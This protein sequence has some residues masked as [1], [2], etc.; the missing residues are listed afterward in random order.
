MECLLAPQLKICLILF[1]SLVLFAAAEPQIIWQD[2]D[3]QEYRSSAI[4]AVST[5]Q[6][7][8]VSRKLS[9]YDSLPVA[10]LSFYVVNSVTPSRIFSAAVSVTSTSS[11][12]ISATSAQLSALVSRQYSSQIT[13]VTA[14]SHSVSTS[15]Q[16]LLSLTTAS[17]GSIFGSREVFSISAVR[18]LSETSAPSLPIYSQELH[19]RLSGRHSAE[20]TSAPLFVSVLMNSMTCA[21][22]RAPSSLMLSPSVAL[23]QIFSVGNLV[24]SPLSLSFSVLAPSAPVSH[25]QVSLSTAKFS[26]FGS[27]LPDSQHGRSMSNPHSLSLPIPSRSIFVVSMVSISVS[28]EATNTPT[29]VPSQ[30]PTVASTFAPT[31]FPTC[32]PSQDP[33]YSSTPTPTLSPSQFNISRLPIT[34]PTPFPSVTIWLLTYTAQ[35]YTKAACAAFA[36]HPTEEAIAKIASA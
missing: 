24:S 34:M 12:P 28:F 18:M 14:H 6:Q 5:L 25:E 33:T 7:H 8:P 9:T 29:L 27:S 10:S 21:S 35:L 20:L 1:L 36:S 30:S 4:S 31:L 3:D 13:Q 19:S 15:R 26:L 32:L 2:F 17:T 22:L 16:S 23:T 11:T